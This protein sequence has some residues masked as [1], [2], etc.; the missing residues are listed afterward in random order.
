MIDIQI[1]FK[2][3][4]VTVTFFVTLTLLIGSAIVNVASP[5]LTALALPVNELI[6]ITDV[7]D[8]ST[9]LNSSTFNAVAGENLLILTSTY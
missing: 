8:D 3:G 7:S 1:E 2:L 5:D 6:S 9:I 4:L